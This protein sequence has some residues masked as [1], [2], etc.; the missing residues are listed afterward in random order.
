[1]KAVNAVF[2]STTALH[3]AGIALVS[4]ELTSSPP[5][6]SSTIGDSLNQSLSGNGISVAVSFTFASGDFASDF[7]TFSF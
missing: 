6:L 1:M 4:F 2:S 5:P 7:K 3:F